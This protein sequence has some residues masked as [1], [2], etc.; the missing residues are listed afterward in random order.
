MRK[1]MR[2]RQW[3][4]FRGHMKCAPLRRRRSPCLSRGNALAPPSAPTR[5]GTHGLCIL[6]LQRIVGMS[7][8]MIQRACMPDLSADLELR[9]TRASASPTSISLGRVEHVEREGIGRRVVHIDAV[10]S[11]QHRWHVCY[12]ITCTQYAPEMSR[13]LVYLHVCIQPLSKSW[14][15]KQQEVASY[16]N[17]TPKMGLGRVGCRCR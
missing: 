3:K 12:A 16:Q 14:Y 5:K 10:R 7:L 8:R 17:R 15:N 1:T 13:A 2:T 11:P 4:G 6:P 9:A